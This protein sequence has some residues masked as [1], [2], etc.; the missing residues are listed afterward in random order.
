MKLPASDHVSEIIFGQN[1]YYHIGHNIIFVT[2][3]VLLLFL[4]LNWISQTISKITN[5]WSWGVLSRPRLGEEVER[6]DI[7]HYFVSV[8]VNIQC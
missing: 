8:F 6:H 5:I 2:F 1:V 7:A 3:S 4:F